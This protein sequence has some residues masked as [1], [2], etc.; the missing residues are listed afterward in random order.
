MT[1]R[2]RNRSIN[3]EL[4]R[5]LITTSAIFPSRDFA[6][7]PM[8]VIDALQSQRKDLMF[9]HDRLDTFKFWPAQMTPDK[10][11]L[12]SYGFFYTGHYDKVTCF[13]C[14]LSVYA[15]DKKD[16]AYEEHHR[17]SPTCAFL[18]MTGKCQ[19]QNESNQVPDNVSGF[20]IGGFTQ[21]T[22]S[23]RF[24]KQTPLFDQF[25]SPK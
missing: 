22:P 1:H 9:Y 11:Q 4:P 19:T 7:E 3:T 13:C 24:V 14:G 20:R 12:S 17:L 5:H 16:H 6:M 2:E 21:P 25:P 10:Y 8:N 15:W 18:K 23:N